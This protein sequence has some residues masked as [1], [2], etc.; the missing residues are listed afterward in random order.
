[1]K[2]VIFWWPCGATLACS[3]AKRSVVKAPCTCL[4]GCLLLDSKEVISGNGSECRY[5]LHI[6]EKDL[7]DHIESGDSLPAPE[8]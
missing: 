3:F 6:K 5:E 4:C 2:N 8:D 1:M 7:R